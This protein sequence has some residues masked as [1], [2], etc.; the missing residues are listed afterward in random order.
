[1]MQQGIKQVS[2]Q[3]FCSAPV[4]QQSEGNQE[5]NQKGHVLQQHQNSDVKHSV[6][7]E[8]RSLEKCHELCA[9][10]LCHRRQ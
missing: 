10:W 9:V 1:M 8:E 5:D 4:F 2:S 7:A 6:L 3:P